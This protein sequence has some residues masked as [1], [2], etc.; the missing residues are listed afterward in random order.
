MVDTIPPIEGESNP[1]QIVTSRKHA[2]GAATKIEASGPG[3]LVIARGLKGLA[4]VTALNEDH[5]RIEVESRGDTLKI[6]FK[7]GLILNRDP[8]GDIRYEIVISELHELKAS[9]GMTAHATVGETKSFKVK[10]ESGSRVSVAELA[11]SSVEAE[12]S[13]GA[14]LT[15]AGT[16]EKEKAKISDGSMYQA[17]ALNADEAEVDASGGAQATIRV[18]SKLKAKASDGAVISYI[19]TDVRLDA[20]TDESGNVRQ[21]A[22]A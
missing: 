19:G 6:E 16:T 18:R 1:D 13:D 9:D 14:Q 20:K 12:A 15:V 8:K 5:E 21:I 7:G 11:V 22:N 10:A 4:T 17:D 2:V 3:T